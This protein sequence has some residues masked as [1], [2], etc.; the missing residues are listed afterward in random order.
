MK[1]LLAII[2]LA[3]LAGGWFIYQSKDSPISNAIDNENPVEIV[4]Q[5]A[6]D[7][8]TSNPL[9]TVTEQPVELPPIESPATPEKPADLNQHS[10]S[11][12]FPQRPSRADIDLTTLAAAPMSDAEFQNLESMIRRDPTLLTDI[13]AEY[14]YNTDPERAKRLAALIANLRDPQILATATE[15]AYSSDPASKRNGLELLSRIQPHNS[16]ARDISIELLSVESDPDF[17]VATMNVLATPAANADSSQKQLLLDN[18]NLLSTHQEPSVRAHS[19][20]LLGRWAKNNP[21]ITTTLVTGLSDESSHVRARAATALR[22]IV[23]P[24]QQT[25]ASLLNVLENPDELKTTRQTAMLALQQMPLT[26]SQKSRFL[27][28]QRALRTRQITQ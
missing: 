5:T 7:Q 24:D 11:A 26:D 4:K 21:D 20:A 2:P 15:L 3:I 23:D 13:L 18:M 17:L 27:A 8:T 10:V 6:P 19:I 1:P 25:I 12:D 22:G 9:S 28:A 16:E 14:R